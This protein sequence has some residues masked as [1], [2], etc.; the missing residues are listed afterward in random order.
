[1]IFFGLNYKEKQTFMNKKKKPTKN[2][3]Q[4]YMIIW[5][6][7]VL[8]FKLEFGYYAIHTSIATLR[9]ISTFQYDF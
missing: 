7:L 9:C 1:M 4:F 8:T 6:V 3:L 5:D 2:Y